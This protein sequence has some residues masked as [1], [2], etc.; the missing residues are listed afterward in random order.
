MSFASVLI[1]TNVTIENLGKLINSSKRRH[2][3][4]FQYNS[5][6]HE[7]IL[8]LSSMSNKFEIF[9]DKI[10]I[11]KGNAPFFHPFEYRFSLGDLMFHIEQQKN[12][13]KLVINDKLFILGNNIHI[14]AV[15]N[16]KMEKSK[17]VAKINQAPIMEL[18]LAKR[19]TQ[20]FP[21]GFVP[22]KLQQIP[23]KTVPKANKI[24]NLFYQNE[25]VSNQNIN[26]FEPPKMDSDN[27]KIRRLKLPNLDDYE[28]KPESFFRQSFNQEN[29]LIKST[30]KK[31]YS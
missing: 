15:K 18:N 17:S 27:G 2:S 16:L 7:L 5:V 21:V 19:A 6:A 3:W 11:E 24:D 14:Y 20:A 26:D 4:S 1:P 13:M 29:E 31:L 8:I 12:N 30:I 22:S 10:E 25:F 9:Y 28:R 23:L